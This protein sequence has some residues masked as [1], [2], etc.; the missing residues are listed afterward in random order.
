MIGAADKRVAPTDRAVANAVA[1]TIARDITVPMPRIDVAVEDGHVTLRGPATGE[2]ER[3]AAENAA[4]RTRGV[5]SVANRM[6]HA[7]RREARNV[8]TGS[9]TTSHPPGETTGTSERAP[10]RLAAPVLAF[11]LAHEVARLHEQAVWQQGDRN[12]KT[13]VKEPDFRLVLIAL[14]AGARMEEH[15][16]AGRISVQT[17]AGHL[18]L[19]TAGTNVDLPVGRLVSLERDVPHDVEAVEES[20][21]LLTIAWQGAHDATG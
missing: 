1:E 13:L 2:L 14:R 3:H 19:H 5:R 7:K 16:A 9:L 20:A 8:S 17:L 4:R 10:Q 6:A 18:R 21:F 12:A 15:R 11:D